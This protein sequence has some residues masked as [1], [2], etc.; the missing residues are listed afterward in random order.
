MKFQMPA[1]SNSTALD[2]T[3]PVVEIAE[4]PFIGSQQTRQHELSDRQTLSLSAPAATWRARLFTHRL[5]RRCIACG[6]M[7][8]EWPLL[9]G[10]CSRSDGSR[11]CTSPSPRDLAAKPQLPPVQPVGQPPSHSPS[12]VGRWRWQGDQLGVLFSQPQQVR[13]CVPAAS[14]LAQRLR[15]HSR[16]GLLPALQIHQHT[17]DMLL[18]LAHRQFC[19]LQST[20]HNGGRRAATTISTHP[21]DNLHP[22]ERPVK[23]PY[24]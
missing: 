24:A 12:A 13:L 22:S 20:R 9:L 17:Y 11:P 2:Q 8:K 6:R 16:S 18:Q 10:I 3:H 7:P 5:L 14:M 1:Q 21:A 15:Q 19:T 23:V 4:I